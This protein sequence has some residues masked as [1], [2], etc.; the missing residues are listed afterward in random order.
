MDTSFRGCKNLL[1]Y[2]WIVETLYTK[3]IKRMHTAFSKTHND[4]KYS[5]TYVSPS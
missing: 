2:K 1:D 4:S 5:L 3:P